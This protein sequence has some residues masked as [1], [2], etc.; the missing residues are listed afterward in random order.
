MGAAGEVLVGTYGID[1]VYQR[2]AFE[3]PNHI[4]HATVY[5]H[6]G[7]ER[8]VVVH[9][10]LGWYLTVVQLLFCFPPIFHN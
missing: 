1:Y 4:T 7:D 6:I 3:S 8:W 9:C 5:K 2:P 10:H